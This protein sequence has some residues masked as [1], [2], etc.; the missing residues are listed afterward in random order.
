MELFI[1]LIV[2][3]AIFLAYKK[4]LW[5]SKPKK[6]TGVALNTQ[7]VRELLQ[8][9]VSFYGKLNLQEK[10][11][12][13]Y[14][15]HLFLSTTKITG[16]KTTLEEL[17]LVLVAASS[18]IPV[19]NFKN[20]EYGFLDEV[21]IYPKAFNLKHK[22]KGKGRAVVGLVGNGYLE[23]KMIL[24]QKSLR[25][26]FK[27]ERDK[28]NVAIHEFLHL[29]DKEDGNIDGVPNAI[30]EQQYVLPWLYL[31]KKKTD[32]IIKNKSD[33]DGYAATNEAEFLTVTGTY[34]FE[35]PH[36]FKSEHPRLYRVFEEMFRIDMTEYVNKRVQPVTKTGRNDNCPCGSGNKFKKCCLV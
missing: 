29:I 19:F 14:R 8:E 17:D 15:V 18:I 21:L 36:Q 9:N 24:S 23:G 20:W 2:A 13:V 16:I 31:M 27:N 4:G 22:L 11:E 30:L 3:A 5:S 26:G 32:E 34:F 25:Q 6:S 12:F 7:K 35:R 33:I 10:D 28:R 1:F